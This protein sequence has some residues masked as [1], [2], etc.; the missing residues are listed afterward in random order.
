[1]PVV[2][3]LDDYYR[4]DAD[5]F[6]GDGLDRFRSQLLAEVAQLVDERPTCGGGGG[7]PSSRTIATTVPLTGG[8]E[9]S[10]DRTLAI[11]DFAASGAGH[12][13]GAVPDPGSVAG[14][15]K[16]LREDATWAVPPAGTE[17][18]ANG[19]MRAAFF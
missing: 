5:G 13:K 4:D 19:K 9:L 1:M 8:G 2:P 16:F 18:A 10:T 15:T 11:S 3:A 17:A 7:I 6:A 12:A 14:T